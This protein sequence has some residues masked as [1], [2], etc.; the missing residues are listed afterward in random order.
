MTISRRTRVVA[1]C[2][3]VAVLLAGGAIALVAL[4]PSPLTTVSLPTTDEEFTNPE[5]GWTDN[6]DLAEPSSM[7]IA[8]AD[9]VTIVRSY[10]RLD[11]YRDAAIPPEELARLEQG[12]AALRASHL[13]VVLR[14]AYNEEGTGADANLARIQEHAQQ[15]KPLLAKNE[16]V[17]LSFEAGFIGAWG[18]WH[19]S[20]NGLATP[21]GKAAVLKAVLAAFPQD[22]MIAL[23]YP[24]DIRTLLR[25]QVTK[26]TA[27]GGSPQARIGNHQDCFLSSDP[28]DVG[29]WGQNGGSVDKD[30]ALIAALSR[31]TIVGGETCA[32]SSRTTCTTALDELARFHFTYLNR[33]F[34]ASAL[35]KLKGDGCLD[36][37]SRRLGYRLAVERFGWTK[38]VGPGGDLTVQLEMKNSGFAHVVNT[39]PVYVVLTKGSK[40][41]DVQLPADPRWWTAGATTT[42]RKTVALPAE[43]TRGTWSM[44]LWLPDAASALQDQ[45]AFSIRLANAG[46]WEA[47]TGLNA[48]PARLTVD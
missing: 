3:T 35:G 5:R 27:Y 17:I 31:Y 18:E 1:L 28:D 10:L 13:K 43:V 21:E 16:D 4:L 11:D 29:T 25:T 23:R 26:A 14:V 40:R 19:D 39:R 36:E 41:V 42:V 15:L 34:D 9:G 45:P 33:Q 20:T 22:R 24:D 32:V 8:V 47:S 30:K 12:F 7:E 38:D 37:I 2:V 6:V 44:A 48:L 46:A